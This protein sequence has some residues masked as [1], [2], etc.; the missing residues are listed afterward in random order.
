MRVVAKRYAEALFELA[1][2][3]GQLDG[4][5]QE[6]ELVA[7]SVQENDT[8]ADFLHH[9][10]LSADEK[11]QAIL[12][13]FGSHLSD[14]SQNFIKLLIDK[15]RQTLMPFVVEEYVELANESRGVSVGEAVTAVHLSDADHSRLEER[16]SKLVGKDVRSE[17]HTS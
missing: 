4:V 17:E 8:F 11:K 2:E 9:P 14:I 16:F 6:I 10:R 1:K 12:N 7:K 13:V 3:R 15:G 5:Q